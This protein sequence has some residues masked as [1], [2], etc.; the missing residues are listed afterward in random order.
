[1]LMEPQNNQYFLVY[2]KF[3]LKNRVRNIL[4]WLNGS[5]PVLLLLLT[6]VVKRNLCSVHLYIHTGELRPI[7][8]SSSF[9]YS[10]FHTP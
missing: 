10:V 1:M 2:S 8:L 7:I 5:N 4:D 6:Q 3:K 9:Y